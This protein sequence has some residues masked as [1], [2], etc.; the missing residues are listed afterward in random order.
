MRGRFIF[1]GE[2][3]AADV[4]NRVDWKAAAAGGGINHGL[5][6]FGVEHFNAHVDN[7]A[8]REILPLFAL[9][10]FVHKI[11][12]GF[13]DNFEIGI[14]ELDVLQRRNANCQ[15]RRREFNFI[16]GRENSSPFFLSG[17]EKILYS[18][19]QIGV[20]FAVV[21]EL[22]RA[23]RF[24]GTHLFVVELGKNQLENFLENVDAR[25]RQ[26][27]IFHFYDEFRQRFVYGDEPVFNFEVFERP[28]LRQNILKFLAG[29]RNIWNILEII[30]VFAVVKR[31]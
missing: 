22:Q 10:G 20:G 7:V 12:K 11:F 19:F 2:L 9:L 15:M 31:N 8:R 21:S 27:F 3:A 4:K 13:V 14:E 5:G 28:A 26:H 25:I 16:F 6:N 17:V 23:P 24:N 30:W 29:A 18:I 1:G